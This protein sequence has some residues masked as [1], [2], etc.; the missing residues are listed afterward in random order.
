MTFKTWAGRHPVIAF[1][2]LTLAWSW[3]IWSL[4]FLLVEQ[5]GLLHDPPPLAYL[6]RIT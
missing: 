2:L 4:L 5:G 3:S 1:T 6:L